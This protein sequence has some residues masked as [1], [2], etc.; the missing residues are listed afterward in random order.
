M[1][2]IVIGHGEWDGDVKEDKGKWRLDLKEKGDFSIYFVL[3]QRFPEKIARLIWFASPF[4]S[5]SK[6]ANPPKQEN[7]GNVF[8]CIWHV[9]IG[10]LT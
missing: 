8:G 5:K 6:G 10:M 4:L 9:F 7:T 1:E 2:E 3:C